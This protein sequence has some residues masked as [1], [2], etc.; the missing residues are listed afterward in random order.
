MEG[1]VTKRKTTH[2]L[3]LSTLLGALL[4][5]LHAVAADP[6]VPMPQRIDRIVQGITLSGIDDDRRVTF[7]QSAITLTN[8]NSYPYND[9]DGAGNRRFAV[10][11]RQAI[12]TGLQCLSGAGPAGYLHNYHGYQAHRL[13]TILE[14]NLPKSFQCVQDRMFA[15]A[16]ATAGRWPD[17][18]DPLYHVLREAPHPAVVLDTY[19]IGGLL[20]RR[21]DAQTYRDFFGLNDRQI[22]EHMTT[23][24][25]HIEGMHRYRN[26]PS[27]LFHEMVH[28]LGHTHSSTEPDLAF[29]YETCCF[30][31]SDYIA[32][33]ALNS[34]VE[35]RACDIL[36]DDSL[37]SANHY[38]KVRLWHHLEYDDFR[39]QVR[40]AD[41]ND[42]LSAEVAGKAAPA[43][44]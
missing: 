29:L 44:L 3:F 39:T 41:D 33:P 32:D 30:G 15:N 8:C 9:S 27:L 22:R 26:L 18:D 14:S 7:Q 6:F 31:G 35:A 36:K 1:D 12:D 19:R 21:H 13:A 37:W 23:S 2:R 17:A 10:H 43:S 38:Q 25:L 40:D 28:W 4:Q 20:T 24:P 5:P 11:L 16:V 34:H 42:A